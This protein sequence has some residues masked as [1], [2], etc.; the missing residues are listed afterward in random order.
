LGDKDLDEK[1]LRGFQ[2]IMR[3]TGAYE[4]A[5]KLSLRLVGQAK[6]E[7]GKLKINTEAK[8]FLNGIADYMIEREL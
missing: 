4:Y 2:E 1:G 7:L 5:K 3:Q 8:D 6:G